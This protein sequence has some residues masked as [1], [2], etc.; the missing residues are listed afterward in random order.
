[1]REH[2]LEARAHERR[3]KILNDRPGRPDRHT[4]LLQAEAL[5]AAQKANDAYEDAE[6]ELRE[7]GVLCEDV[8]HGHA[9][10]PCAHRNVLAWIRFDLFAAEPLHSWRYHNDP[11]ERHRPLAELL[12]ESTFLFVL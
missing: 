5:R 7:L 8:L 4:L 12:A 6:R 3:W 1:M 11:P 9:L 10:L 2:W